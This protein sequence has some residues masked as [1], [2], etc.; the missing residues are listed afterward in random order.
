MVQP[1]DDVL[2]L[3]LALTYPDSVRSQIVGHDSSNGKM[4]NKGTSN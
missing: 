2:I 1:G 4:K 3:L